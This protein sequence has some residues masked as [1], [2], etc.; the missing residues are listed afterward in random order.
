MKYLK[1]FDTH[2]DYAAYIVGA[3][4]KNL[5]KDNVSYC[6]LQKDVHYNKYVLPPQLL[7]ILYS[8]ANGNLSF[9]SEV[10]PTSEGKT[11][12]GLCI[13]EPEFFGENEK[14]RFMSLKYM[15]RTTPETGSL[16]S[17]GMYWG[18]N[19]T[20]INT[21]DNIQTTYNGGSSWGYL[22]ADWITGTDN[23]IP[24]LFTEDN[25]WNISVL[26]TINTYAVTDIDG[27]N[28]TDKILATAT[29]Q[30]TWQTDTTITNNSGANYAPAAC[31]CARYH[32]IGTQAGDWY[33]GAGG[34][35]SMIVVKR[36]EINTKLAAINTIYPNDCVSLLADNKYW[37]STE[38]D[39]NT[40]YYV[41]TSSGSIFNDLKNDTYYVIAM[42]QY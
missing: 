6:K 15:N 22:T 1:I 41:R 40:T 5:K 7:D 29:A 23:K 18:N 2:N 9:T 14:A 31:C 33:L 21:I 12:I 8:D 26:G 28:K 32:T 39:N 24:T 35:M 3:S 16:T 11:P 10:L 17:Q 38:Y 13:V 19:G 4:F 37:T 42:L 27:K 30:T 34:E 20:D 36:N 25:E